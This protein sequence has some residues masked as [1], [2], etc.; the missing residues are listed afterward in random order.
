MFCWIEDLRGFGSLY[1]LFFALVDML[2]GVESCGDRERC[3]GDFW[4]F[5][6]RAYDSEC[7][8]E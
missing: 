1:A 5:S 3:G 4:H 2:V 6:W 8:K 7:C